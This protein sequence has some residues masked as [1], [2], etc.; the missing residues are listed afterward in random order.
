M[1][2]V[3]ELQHSTNSPILF[4]LAFCMV[5]AASSRCWFG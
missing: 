3:I 2:C 1:K 4:W 5:L